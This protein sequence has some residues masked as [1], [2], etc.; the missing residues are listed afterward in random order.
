[1]HSQHLLT[2][3]MTRFCTWCQFTQFQR[4]EKNCKR[5]I[6]I[7]LPPGGF[8]ERHGKTKPYFVSNFHSACLWSNI[9]AICRIVYENQHNRVREK[10]LVRPCCW[11][12]KLYRYTIVQNV[13]RKEMIIR[14]CAAPFVGWK[15]KKRRQHLPH[16]FGTRCYMPFKTWLMLHGK[17]LEWERGEADVLCSTRKQ[18]SNG[19]G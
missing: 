8:R 18:N 3:L 5:K 17:S 16:S 14:H 2:H 10:V 11:D 15:E 4:C 9:F 1:M 6:T 13:W 19:R 7:E 12:R